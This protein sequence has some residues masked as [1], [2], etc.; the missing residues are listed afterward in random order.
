MKRVSSPPVPAARPHRF[1]LSSLV[2]II[3]LLAALLVTVVTAPPASAATPATDN[4]NRPN[5]A[6]G[7]NWTAMTDGAMAI[8]SQTVAGTTAAYSGAIRTAETFSADQS[9]HLQITVPQLTGNQQIG[10]GVRAQNGGKT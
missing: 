1:S 2:L 8:T 6:L 5:G 3:T 9:S 10:V 7:P 4:F